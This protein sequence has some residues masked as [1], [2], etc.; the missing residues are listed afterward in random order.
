M[1]AMMA[2]L[3]TACGE[4]RSGE[5]YALIEKDIWI[6]EVMKSH[7]L[8]Y[9][10]MPT[11][12]E[13]AYFAEPADFLKKLVYSKALD[14]KGDSFSYIEDDADA[15]G[16]TATRS[17][18]L[19]RT[20]TYGFD[21]ELLSDP[22][23]TS[24]YTLARV[25]F[26]LPGSPAAQ[27]GLQRGDW[28]MKVNGVQISTSNYGYLQTGDG[29]SLT[30]VTPQDNAEGT[31]EWT[32]LDTLTLSAARAIEVNPFYKDSVYTV[33]GQRIA[34]L[35]YDSFTTGPTDEATDDTY[36]Q[37]MLSLFAKFKQQRPDAFVLDLRYNP[38]G[39]LSC[40]RL[41][42]A[43]LAPSSAL[44]Q[45]FCTLEYNDITEPQR[46]DLTFPTEAASANLN[47]Q[48]V[49][50][51][52]SKYTAS[53]S[54][55]VINCLRPYMGADNVITIGETTY[56]KPVA[57][58]S[59]RNDGFTFTFWPVTSYVLNA[60]GEADYAKGI[61]P[62]YAF[63]ERSK[64]TLYPIGDTQEMLLSNAI[65][66]ITTGHVTDYVPDDGV[67]PEEGE[68]GSEEGEDGSE[69]T[70][71]SAAVYSTLAAKAARGK[72]VETPR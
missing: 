40:A 25:L 48:K 27:A 45:T 47:L 43:L 26:V 56:G 33:S 44:G 62:T 19:D 34:Y 17:I 18:F 8:W 41:L 38:G 63:N 35:M 32:T 3:L 39:Y 7:Y 46:S 42:A 5:Y 29:V 9:D 67:G 72:L 36:N 13:S 51:L 68:D 49:Y 24:T 6:E 1:A 21:F 2:F 64:L 15:S 65:S 30:R 28:L 12:T 66:L 71:V 50:I 52:T 22:L 70:E 58:Q 31:T 23:G 57:M 10:Q 59:F 16:T 61:A 4:D 60:D 11:V 14:G 53:A 20:S 55:A 69:D 37:Q 54:E